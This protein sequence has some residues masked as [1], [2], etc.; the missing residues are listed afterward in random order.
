MYNRGRVPKKNEVSLNKLLKEI[1]V[2][3]K[4]NKKENS[5]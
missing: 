3:K 5:K 2:Y 4:M 1:I